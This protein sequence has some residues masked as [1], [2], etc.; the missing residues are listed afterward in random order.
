MLLVVL[1]VFTMF[2]AVSFGDAKGDF[3]S[4]LKEAT[5]DLNEKVTDFD[6]K[7]GELQDKLEALLKPPVDGKKID[8]A[9]KAGTSTY[10]DLQ[11][12]LDGALD[13]AK[14]KCGEPSKA[15]SDAKQKS[16][17]GIDKELGDYDKAFQ[18]AKQRYGYTLAQDAMFKDVLSKLAAAKAAAVKPGTATEKYPPS[19]KWLKDNENKDDSAT[20]AIRCPSRDKCMAPG[21]CTRSEVDG[22]QSKKDSLCNQKR[23]CSSFKIKAPADPKNIKANEKV[24]C[25]E[26][27]RLISVGEDCRDQRTKVMHDCFR[28]GNQ[29]HIDERAEVQ[30]VIDDCADRL[31]SAKGMKICK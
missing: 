19:D 29:A 15:K 8:D 21:T 10:A 2:P 6:K 7:S 13:K 4:K 22:L 12:K 24:D 28:D 14:D 30:S 18:A 31:K 3:V 1:A 16:F 26:M 11:N 5:K 17:T 20:V 27:A 25:G 9:I 23:S